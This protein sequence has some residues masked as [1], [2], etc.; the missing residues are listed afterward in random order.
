MGRGNQI[1]GSVKIWLVGL[2][3]VIT[4][5]MKGMTNSAAVARSSVCPSSAPIERRNRAL[6]RATIVDCGSVCC[7]AS[8]LYLSSQAALVVY[9][10]VRRANH[11]Q[12]QQH[13]D[14]K[15]HH[16]HRRSI[17]HVKIA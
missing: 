11:D 7:M 15:H 3:E 13:Q 6:R 8:P 14:D 2:S 5:Q 12:R 9:P 4:S 17:A 1:K 16:R 10:V